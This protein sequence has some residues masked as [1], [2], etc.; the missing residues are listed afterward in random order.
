M[1][2]AFLVRIAVRAASIVALMAMLV[3]PGPA[4][5]HQRGATVLPPD[6]RPCGYS[7]SEMTRRLALFT[8]SGND[9]AYYPRTPF[10]ILYFDP[11]T[12][13]VDTSGDGWAFSGTN[14][15][16]VPAGTQFFVP[17]QNADDSPPVLGTLPR[18][19]AEAASYFFDPAQLGA[20][21][22]RIDVDGVATPIGPRYVAGP[23]RTPPLLDGGGRHMITLGAFVGPLPPGKHTVTIDGGLYG[24]LLFPA[25]GIRFLRG[26]FSYQ[27][28][29]AP[30]HPHR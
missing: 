29:V 3:A 25:Y 13:Q 8:T 7:L 21:G 22:Y 17:L 2:R 4:S 12:A 10:Q 28:S 30:A 11:A 19:Q 24:D 26:H 15:F 27:V 23:V 18:S 9:Q 6:A 5:A 14:T 16:S 1:S 20:K